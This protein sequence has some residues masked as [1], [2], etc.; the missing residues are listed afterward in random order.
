VYFQGTGNR[1][2][3][4]NVDNPNGDNIQPGCGD[5]TKATPFI[6]GDSIFFEGTDNKLLA[7][8]VYE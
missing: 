6:S 3:K 1:L 5:S 2:F 4:V 8:G 7:V